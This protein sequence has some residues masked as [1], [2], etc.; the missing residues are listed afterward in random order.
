[1]NA[2]FGPTGSPRFSLWLND[3]WPILKRG[4]F[5]ASAAFITLALAPL[6][7]ITVDHFQLFSFVAASVSTALATAVRWFDDNSKK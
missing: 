4:F 3:A 5:G 2:R 6:V 1:M 7:G